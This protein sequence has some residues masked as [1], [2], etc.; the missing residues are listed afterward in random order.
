MNSRVLGAWLGVVGTTLLACGDD[1]AQLGSGAGDFGGAS[2]GGNGSGGWSSG[3]SYGYGGGSFGGNDGGPPPPSPIPAPPE[4]PMG[5]EGL[6]PSAP[7]VLYV[8]ADDSNSMASPVRARE[9]LRAGSSA[10]GS[11]RTYEFFNYYRFDY[12][13][14]TRGQLNLFAE[15]VEGST[16]G[17]IDLQFAVRSP[18][19]DATRRDM[20]ITF[21]LDT[22]GSMEGHGIER[23]RAA[24]LA[25]ASKLQ[26]GDIVNAVTWSVDQQ[27]VLANHVAT[28]PNDSA[29][30]AMAQGLAPNG[31][32]DLDA[33][34][35]RGYELAEQSYDIERLN[36][37]VVISDGVANVGVTAADVI[38]MSSELGDDEGI[39]LVGI[40]TGPAGAYNDELMDFV[41]DKG[42]GAYIYLD[43]PEEAQAILADRF[44]EV[45]EVSARAVRLE[46]TVPWYFQM[47]KFY[48]EEY[49]E[50]PAEVKPQ[51]LAPGDTMVLLQ[52]LKACDPT[53]LVG[54][55][56]VSI[57]ASW[58]T[59]IT[60]EPNSV[61]LE[62]TVAE[63]LGSP[64]LFMPKGKAI[65]AY[66]DALRSGL[67]AD[68]H[69]AH[70]RVQ[71]ANVGGS[72]AD[73][74]EIEQLL[75][76]HPAF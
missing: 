24:I 20:T 8:S 47:Q 5:C 10:F 27:V 34:L 22:S 67:S 75:E 48:G 45:M 3:G 38:A 29:V 13:A 72:D 36:R 28:G 60:H 14:P 39:Y 51:H 73:L 66:A 43:E 42:R 76:A 35:I 30:V 55:D 4:P 58:N 23:E 46:L 49:S 71:A 74:Q 69:A 17:S 33:G 56:P 70:A 41:T 12:P 21:V 32:T 6:D 64:T 16:P 50:N 1:A 53:L 68:L 37:L 52:T 57:E 65:A 54:S 19:P 31:G 26:A 59:P 15:A 61:T 18:D 7:L 9:A 44:D 62:T 11:V 63:L 25:L 2:S 40:G